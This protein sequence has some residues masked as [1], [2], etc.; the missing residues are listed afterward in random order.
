MP[1]LQVAD[2]L[3]AQSTQAA[4]KA[5]DALLRMRRPEGYWWADLTADTT[6]ESDFIMLQLWLYPP[7]G[8]EWNPP[9]R[10]L[11]DK[12]VASILARQL[13]DGGFNIYA[14]G[15]SEISASVKAYFALKVAGVPADS[16]RMVQLR[17]R[18]LAL[19]G[20]QRVN[21]YVKINLSL[22]GL[23]PREYVP[24]IPPEFMLLGKIIYEMSSWTRAI[25]IPLSV[26][27]A[28]NPMRPVPEGFTLDEIHAPGVS[29]AFQW[30]TNPFTWKNFFLAVDRALKIW[31][32]YGSKSIRQRAIKKA[33]EW[34]LERTKDSDG[35]AAIYPPMQYLIMALDV[36]GVPRNHP[37]HLEATRQFENLMVNDGERFFFQP[38]FSPVWDTAI[39]AF[40]VGESGLAPPDALNNTAEWLLSKEV[41]KKGDWSVKRP[42][43]EP[44]G[45]Y[46]EFA[47]EF[48]PDID[49][50]GMVLLA[51]KHARA[52]DARR[53]QASIQ[54]AVNWLLAMQ[55]KDGGW[56]A[57]DVDNNW[58]P[59]AEVP[60][61][62]HN[63]MLDPTCPDI[64]GRVME[65]LLAQGVPRHHPAIRRAV[66]YLRRTQE[67]DGSWYGRW[68]VD[69][70]YGTFLALRGL[71]A[72]G[73]DLREAYIL[74][75]AE[76]LRS[77]QNAD[78]GWGESCESYDANTYV[79]A[80]STP[81][82][83]AWAVM[84]LIA[85]GDLQSESVRRGVEY[86]I[87]TQRSDG[88]WDEDLS[89]GT[90]FPRVFYLMYH[91]YRNSFPTMALAAFL[92]AKP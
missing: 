43:V 44:S 29:F 55:S 30:E 20:L 73:E 52:R 14:K 53:Q 26:V 42:N 23:Y 22:F 40:A 60:F 62:D 74:R 1:S 81:S 71:R 91:L 57:F 51:F 24:S 31:E 5:V 15:P 72:A 85:S 68:G 88:T 76:W 80:P 87:E 46:F 77:I 21:S 8:K 34:A 58:K 6:L 35:L 89:T 83:T 38:C 39:A 12:A 28:H 65:G 45:W 64:T 78:G 36:T 16:P 11:V 33:M 63:A 25:V 27:Q 3:L 79:G 10:D 37:D 13:P 7:E 48:Y 50:T 47:N 32:K 66:A 90:G 61:A 75:A 41:R 92:N 82:Q 54:R 59:L 2:E 9:T 69:Y 17:E 86:L 67:A 18:I 49:D 56:A 84:G 4:R 70:I 19:G